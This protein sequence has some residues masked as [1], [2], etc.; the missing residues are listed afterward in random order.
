MK[1][2]VKVLHTRL[3]GDEVRTFQQEAQIIADLKH[4]HMFIALSWPWQTLSLAP[5]P[6]HLPALGSLGPGV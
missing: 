5:W 6:E 2:A 4:P 1:A 3:N